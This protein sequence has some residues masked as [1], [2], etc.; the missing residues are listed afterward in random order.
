MRNPL[1]K[2]R[3]FQPTSALVSGDDGALEFTVGSVELGL[4]SDDAL[5]EG[6][7]SHN[8]SVTTLQGR[9]V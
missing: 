9:L 7:K 4:V 3:A 6:S 8:I 1:R 2:S 5:V